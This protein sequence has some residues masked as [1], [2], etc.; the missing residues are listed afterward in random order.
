MARAASDATAITGGM[1]LAALDG[2]QERARELLG[3]CT[4]AEITQAAINLAVLVID[5]IPGYA[6]P[7]A[8]ICVAAQVLDQ[9]GRG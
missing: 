9:V 2:D 3:M 6:R 5:D 4:R 1:L 8:R 7:A